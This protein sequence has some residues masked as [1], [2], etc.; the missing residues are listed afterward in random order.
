MAHWFA[1]SF[2]HVDR[3]RGSAGNVCASSRLTTQTKTVAE[4]EASVSNQRGLALSSAITCAETTNPVVSRFENAPTSLPPWFPDAFVR[5]SHGSGGHD[6]LIA[7][8]SPR[9]QQQEQQGHKG[10][11][12]A[13]RIPRVELRSSLLAKADWIWMQI[14]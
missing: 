2:Y 1:P 13:R 4:F 9:V 8:H 14:N 5:G 6:S 11:G 12:G 7:P 3:D 10:H